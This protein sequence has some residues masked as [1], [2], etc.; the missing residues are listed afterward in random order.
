MAILGGIGMG[1]RSSIAPTPI[2]QRIAE[3]GG[4]DALGLRQRVVA[5]L[6]ARKHSHREIGDLVGLATETVKKLATE[7]SR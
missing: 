2:S 7:C 3:Q 4:G 5:F 1:R 6:L